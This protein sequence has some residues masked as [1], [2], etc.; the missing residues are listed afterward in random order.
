MRKSKFN[1]I[2]STVISTILVASLSLPVAAD[3]VSIDS[4]GNVRTGVSNTNGNFEVTGGSGEHAIVGSTSGTWA[5]GLYG[6]NSTYGTYGILGYGTTGV[7]GY[8]PDG[9]A[10]YFQGH[11][12]VT[13]NLTVDGTINYTET[14]PQVGTLTNGKWCTSDG[15]MVNCTSNAPVTTET[16]P[17]VNALGKA[18]L[19]CSTNQIA[20]WNGSAW[21]CAA[22]SNTTYTAG[23]GLNLAGTTFNAVVPFSLTGSVASPNGI[24]NGS[25]SGT[26]YGVY[27]VNTASNNYGGIG[28]SLYGVYGYGSGVNS[29]VY[30][31]NVNGHF[32]NL[33]HATYG[34]YGQ[35][36]NGNV[37]GLGSGSYGV[38]GTSGSG[39]A[40]YFSSTSGYGLIV[41]SGNTGIGTSTPSERLE[42]GGNV[43]ITSSEPFLILND[44]SYDGIRPRIRFMNNLGIFDSDDGRVQSFGFYSTF[45]STR[46]NDANIRVYGKATGNWGRYIE[47]THDGTKGTISTDS[48]NIQINPSGGTVSVTG[49]IES[50]SGGVKFP[51]GTTQTTASA[52]SWHQ[53]LPAAQRFTLVMNNEAVLDKETGLV[54]EKSPGSNTLPWGN[55]SACYLKTLGGRK[56]WRTPTVEELASLIDPSMTSP[57]L[58]VGH[59]FTNVQTGYYWSSTTSTSTTYAGVV[60]L[61]TGDIS[62]ELKTASKYNWCVRGGQGHDAY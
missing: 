9:W 47:M 12:R 8:S 22:D 35:S 45:S 46:T 39:T 3:D 16:D 18:S 15:T 37:G 50:T 20:K 5:A 17:T 27:G 40:A 32:G 38:Y 36:S 42:V 25:N 34:V 29:G 53:V 13:G 2:F 62:I 33:G 10:G 57:A 55:F 14:D 26:G 56:G 6:V 31:T 11:A 30:G 54:W 21:A 24:I 44:T 61:Y 51:D 49:T 19:S 52:P 23:M 4:S 60:S 59:P 28:S 41:D 7:Y 1:W 43:K 58:P 48:G